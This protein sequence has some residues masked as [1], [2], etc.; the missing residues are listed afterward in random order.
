MTAESGSQADYLAVKI[1][2]LAAELFGSAW[3]RMLSDRLQQRWRKSKPEY[4]TPAEAHAEIEE[5]TSRIARRDG[6]E[7]SEVRSKFRSQESE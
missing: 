4:L 2:K 7:I 5:L 3:D 1:G 6:K